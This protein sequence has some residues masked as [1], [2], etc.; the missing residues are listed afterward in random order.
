MSRV[1]QQWFIFFFVCLDIY[2]YVHLSHLTAASTTQGPEIMAGMSLNLKTSTSVISI[3]QHQFDMLLIMEPFVSKVS[4]RK[5]SQLVRVR[6]SDVADKIKI[7]RWNKDKLLRLDGAYCMC[8]TCQM[9]LTSTCRGY[10][11]CEVH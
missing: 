4:L 10:A 7:K 11:L 6:P 5:C 1:F 2:I 9:Y 8:V 3:S